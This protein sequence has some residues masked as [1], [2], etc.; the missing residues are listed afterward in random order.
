M[1]KNEIRSLIK[2]TLPKYA[3]GSEYH[4]EVVNRAI[5]KAINQL[6]TET[7]LRDPHSIQRYVKR[8]TAVAVSYDATALIYYSSFPT[9]TVSGVSITIMPVPLPDKASGIRRISTVAQGGIT[10]FPMDQREM[11][12]VSDSIFVNSVNTKIGYVVTQDRVE[13]Y[14]MDVATATA[15]VRMDILVPFSDYDETDQILIPEMPES[16]G[17]TFTDMVL[18]ILGVIIPQETI[19]DNI[20]NFKTE[21]TKE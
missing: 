3:Q 16:G 9:D 6:Y 20:S 1:Q 7:F 2:N 19:D 8:F 14:N 10:F 12:L 11:E 17:K 18:A 4:D 13:Y 21:K 15:G 5:E